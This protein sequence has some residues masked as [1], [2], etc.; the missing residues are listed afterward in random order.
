MNTLHGCK[1]MDVHLDITSYSAC[2]HCYGVNVS[3]KGPVLETRSPIQWCWEVN[4]MGGVWVMR[5]LSS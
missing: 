2:A 4:L 1:W 5:A 3:S